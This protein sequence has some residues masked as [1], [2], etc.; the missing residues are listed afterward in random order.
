VDSGNAWWEDDHIE[1]YIDANGSRPNGYTNMQFQ[2]A[3]RR[4]S[5]GI[6]DAKPWFN[7]SIT[8]IQVSNVEKPNG[9]GYT[10]EIKIPFANLGVA[11]EAYKFIGID[12]QIGDDDDGGSADT[13]MGWF[14]TTNNVHQNPSL[15]A[16]AQLVEKG[17]ADNIKPTIP[18]DLKANAVTPNG[19]TISWTASDD[20]FAVLSYEVFVNGNLAA[21]PTGTS[22]TLQD[23]TPGTTYSVQVKAKDRFGNLSDPSS[24]LNVMTPTKASGVKYQAELAAFT[25]GTMVVSGAESGFSGT[26]YVMQSP[27]IGA[28]ITFTVNVSR[29][30]TYPVTLRYSGNSRFVP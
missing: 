6:I 9:E 4:E 15:M 23:L 20:N 1:L 26:G 14:S 21:T 17:G 16:L 18:T 25:A 7:R 10:V 27:T 13:R 12:V 29:A 22:L 2:Y 3:V 11:A 28:A 24:V 5:N 30:G 19:F 8:N